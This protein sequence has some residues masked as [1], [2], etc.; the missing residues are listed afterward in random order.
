MSAATPLGFH[1]R[2]RRYFAQRGISWDPH[3]MWLDQATPAQRRRLLRKE[4][5]SWAT[6]ARGGAREWQAGELVP[7][8]SG[9]ATDWPCD[10][11][12]LPDPY[13]GTGDGIGSCGCPRCD[14]G[15]AAASSV[16]CA[17]PP[18]DYYDPY[19]EAP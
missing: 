9:G 19:G 5:R 7:V 17:C 2:C 6:A 3:R 18:D 16:L 14:G 10:V 8:R 12:G 15:E 4:R 13:Q 1:A 11:C